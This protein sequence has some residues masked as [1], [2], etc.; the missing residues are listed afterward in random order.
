MPRARVNGIDTHYEVQGEGPPVLFIH[1]GFGGPETTVSPSPNVVTEVLVEGARLVTYDRRSCG[2]S[3]YVTSEY[4]LEDLAAD[5]R[6]LLDHLGIERS[7]VVGSSMGGMVAQQYALLYPERVTALALLNTGPDLMSVT[8]WG[9]RMTAI[10]ER[11]R[12]EGDRAVFESRLEA[13]RNP[14]LPLALAGAPDADERR[15]AAREAVAGLSDE[16]LSVYSTGAVRNYGAFAGYDFTPRLGE[17]SMPALVIHGSADDTVPPRC[18]R[19]LLDGIPHAEFCEVDGAVHGIL[20]YAEA[21][22]ALREWVAR[23]A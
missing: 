17:L 12:S 4:G 8:E 13:L 19:A 9:R 20:A 2:Q 22:A 10:A 1:G 5:A 3:E 16:E 11:A 7:V 6:A 14:P 18:G 21:Q 15:R 23:V